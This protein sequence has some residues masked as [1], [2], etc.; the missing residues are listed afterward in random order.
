MTTTIRIRKLA[1]GL[2]NRLAKCF[3]IEWHV[4]VDY[5]VKLLLLFGL[6]RSKRKVYI[7]GLNKTGTSSLGEAM[8]EA[9]C[10]HLSYS[11]F[12]IKAFNNRDFD[13]LKAILE[14]FDSFDDKP[15][16]DPA[17]W[18]LMR[19]IQPEALW[20]YTFRD[21]DK[22]SRSYLNYS[23]LNDAL[24]EVVFINSLVTKKFVEKHLQAAKDFEKSNDLS[25]VWLDCDELSHRGSALLSAAMGRDLKIGHH[26]SAQSNKN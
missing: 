5:R 26:N 1:K 24:N 6:R 25:F 11:P 17:I 4:L 3:G 16:N 9:G 10:R 2:V 14:S 15:W 20:C 8:R 7:V 13:T 12:A 23:E 22:W 19:Q 18:P 21:V